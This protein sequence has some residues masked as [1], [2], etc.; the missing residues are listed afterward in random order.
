MLKDRVRWTL[1]HQARTA[2]LTTYRDPDNRLEL[3]P[4]HTIHRVT[5]ALESLVAEDVAAS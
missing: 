2:S 4:P 5:Q 3:E 1:L